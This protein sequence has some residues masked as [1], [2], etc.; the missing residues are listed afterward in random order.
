LKAI[1]KKMPSASLIGFD[2]SSEK[3]E[4]DNITFITEYCDPVQ[5]IPRYKPD[6]V[7]IRHVLEHLSR[8]ARMV[9]EVSWGASRISKKCAL[10]AEVPC[11]DN[12][13][14]SHRYADFFYEHVSHFTTNSFT[15]L[16]GKSGLS[17]KI[18]HGYKNEVIYGLSN[19]ERS[20]ANI[21]VYREASANFKRAQ[22][23][24]KNM[25]LSINDLAEQKPNV[26]IW[27]GSGK[28]AMFL[29]LYGLSADK[30]PLV[31]DS[32]SKKTGFFV[33]GTGQEIKSPQSVKGS[34]FDGVIIPMSWRVRDIVDEMNSLDIT[35]DLIFTEIDGE[36]IS[37][38]IKEI[39]K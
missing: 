23:N 9:E 32:D 8:P 19:L 25:R 29:N 18:C 6:L 36:L 10:Y 2:P 35:A 22:C 37:S 31:V 30:F 7:I 38:S 28:A 34:H 13:I 39:R 1:S 26:A 3:I 16:M 5:D 17:Y 33:P 4:T 27:G 11:I 20:S 15:K 14:L 24:V 12:S 21:Q